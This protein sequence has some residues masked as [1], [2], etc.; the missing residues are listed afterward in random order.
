MY[1]NMPVVS[2]N[3]MNE[4][5][6]GGN[7]KRILTKERPR[8]QLRPNVHSYGPKSVAFLTLNIYEY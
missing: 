1:G 4:V 5:V 8:P 6:S 2:R 7:A 3:S